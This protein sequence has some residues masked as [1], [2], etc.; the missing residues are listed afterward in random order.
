MRRL[1]PLLGLAFLAP[2]QAAGQTPS[3]ALLEAGRAEA[4]DRLITQRVFLNPRTDLCLGLGGATTPVEDPS[5][6]VMREV[7]RRTADFRAS[8]RYSG[9]IMPFSE[10]ESHAFAPGAGI[11]RWAVPIVIEALWLSTDE[12]TLTSH[13]HVG[14]TGQNVL[15]CRMTVIDVGSVELEQC[16]VLHQHFGSEWDRPSWSRRGG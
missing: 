12:Q 15:D 5:D 10:C 6:E 8:R 9:E 3:D 13:G 14:P 1:V 11:G 4:F 16:G 7:E 2:L